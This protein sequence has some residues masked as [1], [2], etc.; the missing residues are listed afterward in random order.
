[1]L[2]ERPKNEEKVLELMEPWRGRPAGGE[3]ERSWLLL[4]IVK[5]WVVGE[6]ESGVVL[7]GWLFDSSRFV[8]WVWV[9][10]GSAYLCSQR[11]M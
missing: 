10:G 11:V 1:M 9:R 8:Q 7:D 4:A 5:Y 2:L 6:A 3:S